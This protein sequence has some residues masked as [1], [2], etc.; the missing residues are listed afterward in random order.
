MKINNKKD[1]RNYTLE[2]FQKLITSIGQKPFRAKQLYGWVYKRRAVSIDEMTELSLSLR[3]RLKEDSFFI[4]SPK[5]LK[6]LTS[7]D[8]TVKLLLGL[9]DDVRIECVLIPD[10]KRL[11]LCLSSQAG[12]S[13][14]CEFCMTGT[15]GAG[16]NLTLSELAGQFII[17]NDLIED[18]LIEGHKRIS[19]IV[20]M[21]MGE[22]FLNYNNVMRFLGVL[23]DDNGLGIGPRK[24][25]VSTSGIVSK[26]KMFG[27]DHGGASLAVSLNA[28]TDEVRSRLMPIND[29][30]PLNKLIAAL[31]AYPLKKREAITIEY[32]LIKDV[33]DTPDDARRLVKLLGGIK[34]K[35]NLIPF[36]PYPGSVLTRP[37]ERR[38]F[39]FQKILLDKKLVAVRRDSRGADVGAAC[40]Q[41]KGEG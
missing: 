25:T 14:E 2:E 3:E 6:Q 40:G 5:L 24:V 7:K 15:M 23:T 12:C 39:T 8:G 13:L 29:K 37:D 11:T 20:M 19:N 9:P 21:G 31:R 35:I 10:E 28:T 27:E 34:V 22:P 32:V 1:L 41:L 18:G 38:V 16:R 17:A 30:Y 36:N 33:N 4:G 26:I